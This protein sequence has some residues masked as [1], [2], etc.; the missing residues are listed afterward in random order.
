M[1]TRDD[2]RIVLYGER[3]LAREQDDMQILERVTRALLSSDGKDTSERALKYSRRYQQLVAEMRSRPPEKR[4]GQAHWQDDLDRSQAD[5]LTLEAHSTGNLGEME[6]AIAL[7]KQAYTVF[8]AT[9]SAREIAR[10]L[11]RSGK[12]EE[13]IPYLAEAFVLPD[14]RNSEADRAADRVHM[15]ELY[16]KLKGSEKGLGDLIL[17][18]YD[19][20]TA[21]AAERLAKLNLI[22]PNIQAGGAL[23]FTLPGLNGAKLSLASLRGKAVVFD[24]WATWCAPCRAQ[25]P[26]YEEVKKKYRFN[27]DV[28]FLS[29]NTDEDRSLVEPFLKEQKWSPIVYF[30]DG[31]SRKLEISSIP[32]TLIVNRKGEIISRLN[33]FLPNRFVDMLSERIDEALK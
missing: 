29:V 8:P 28:V 27:P 24:F 11:S 12:D 3:V 10:W 25:H 18:A 19:R 17:E 13:A 21:R 26:L 22:D 16:R 30:E 6:K 31:M 5:A 7:A 1:E 32:M 14:P 23:D 33:G 20:T 15:G 2:R 9:E 4:V